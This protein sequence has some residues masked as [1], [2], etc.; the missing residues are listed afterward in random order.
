MSCRFWQLIYN[1]L[2]GLAMGYSDLSI[3][4]IRIPYSSLGLSYYADCD[5]R[6]DFYEAV[7][8][9]CCPCIEIGKSATLMIGELMVWP[10]NG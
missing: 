3:S 10:I 6:L 9:G 4:T 5:Y 8:M 2:K 7:Q 1:D